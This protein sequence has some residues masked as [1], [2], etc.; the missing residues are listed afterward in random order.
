[1]I[2]CA[3]FLLLLP[4]LLLAG[5]LEEFADD[6]EYLDKSYQ[7]VE[8]L[9]TSSAYKTEYRKR[10][11]GARNRAYE[12][13][14][15]IE[16]LGIP[17]TSL[18]STLNKM[19]S[20]MDIDGVTKRG[21]STQAGDRTGYANDLRRQI[22]YLQELNYSFESN[23]FEDP[24][25]ESDT[26]EAVHRFESL[27]KSAFRITQGKGYVNEGVRKKYDE[28]FRDLQTLGKTIS[29]QVQKRQLKLPKG[30][31]LTG[32]LE[33][34]QTSAE[35]VLSVRN[36]REASNSRKLRRLVGEKNYKEAMNTV[37]YAAERLEYEIDFLKRSNF[38]LR[39]RKT[40]LLPVSS[41]AVPSAD[42][43]TEQPDRLSFS[44]LWKKY[45]A[46]KEKVFRS[47]SK[48]R[49]VSDTFYDN[50]RKL[51]T[52]SQQKELDA[53]RE[54][55]LREELSPELARSMAVKTMHT[56]YRFSRKEFTAPLLADILKK[57]GLL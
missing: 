38:E 33:A 16:K 56:K 12:L 22:S 11:V 46:A 55:F 2:R 50:Y 37:K 34:F 53:L 7:E 25:P 43:I 26:Y 41:R 1:M 51:L 6:V 13:Q 23:T 24:Y 48:L 47:E 30:F 4:G 36:R 29:M 54:K 27:L 31:Q 19:I 21:V 17:K 52:D 18:D 9:P 3:L 5:K 20:C 39:V 10:I 32:N 35:K 49:G 15:A 44:E 14:R 45:S 8:K 57:N 40:N 28:I 42:E